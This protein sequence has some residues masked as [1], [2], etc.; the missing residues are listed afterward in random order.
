MSLLMTK[1]INESQIVKI[2][3]EAKAGELF[4]DEI[5]RNHGVARSILYAW[6]DKYA[7]M[8]VADIKRLKQLEEEN[9]KLKQMYGGLIRSYDVKGYH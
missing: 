3:E 8:T 2:L 4:I 6:R 5:C 7:G 9:R 1:R